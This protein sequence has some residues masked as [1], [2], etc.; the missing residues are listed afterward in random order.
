M[1]IVIGHK[2]RYRI[3]STRSGSFALNR[4]INVIN[5]KE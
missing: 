5:S 3:L 4:M 2:V 1:L